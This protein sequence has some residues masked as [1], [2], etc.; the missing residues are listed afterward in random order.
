MKPVDQWGPALREHREGTH[1]E[2]TSGMKL[3]DMQF[4]VRT[5]NF[6]FEIEGMAGEFLAKYADAPPPTESKSLATLAQCF[7][8]SSA[9]D[10]DDSQIVGKNSGKFPVQVSRSD[11]ILGSCANCALSS[12]SPINELQPP[13]L[14]KFCNSGNVAAIDEATEPQLNGNA[15]IVVCDNKDKDKVTA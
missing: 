5:Y 6:N 3:A 8:G 2:G 9:K 14:C 12:Q 15:E 13:P 10:A 7:I 1:Y 4:G 11:Y